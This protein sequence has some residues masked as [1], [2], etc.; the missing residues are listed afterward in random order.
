[1]KKRK[2]KRKVEDTASYGQGYLDCKE[3]RNG[4]GKNHDYD[5][6]WIAGYKDVHGIGWEPLYNDF[7][8]IKIG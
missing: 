6:G 5:L 7:I 8:K 3:G 1:M 4:T 2:D